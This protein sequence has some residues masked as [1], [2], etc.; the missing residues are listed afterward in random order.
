[1]K[2]NEQQQ[3]AV[4]EL[5]VSMSISAG[6]GSGKTRV[7][8]ERFRALVESGRAGID[9]IL[10]VTFTRKAAHEL[11]ERVR[12]RIDESEIAPNIKI[13]LKES[14]SRAYIGTIHSFCTRLL[15]ENPIEA[16][17]DPYFMVVEELPA[18]ELLARTAED[19]VLKQIK[20]GSPEVLAL[21]ELFGYKQLCSELQS[22]NRTLT[23]KGIKIDQI[24]ATTLKSLAEQEQLLPERISRINSALQ[25]LAALLPETDSN[26]KTYSALQEIADHCRDWQI[27]TEQVITEPAE[28]LKLL[29]HLQALGK[30]LKARTVK[31]LALELKQ[32]ADELIG[33]LTDRKTIAVLKT[34]F[35]LLRMVEKELRLRKDKRNMLEFSDLEEKAVDLLSGHPKIL[36][37]YQNHF[38]QIMVDEFQDTNYRQ[39]Q[40][41]NLL[42]G[43]ESGRN[44]FVVGDP[45]QSIYRFR[46]AEVGLFGE[47]SEQVES[48]GGIKHR[49][50]ENY[51]TREQVIKIINR[52][53]GKLMQTSEG[54][55]FQELIA[56]RTNLLSYPQV[57]L[58]LLQRDN[59]A[60]L[61]RAEAESECLARRIGELVAN[62]G[63]MVSEEEDANE[64]LRPVKYGDIAL[65]F[66]TAR[67]MDA[68]AATFSKHGIPSFIVGSRGFYQTEEIRTIL[69]VLK[70]AECCR[71]EMALA[72]MLRSPMFG[73]SDETLWLMKQAASGLGKAIGDLEQI[74]GMDKFEQAKVLMARNLIN[75]IRKLKSRF[76]LIEIIDRILGQTGFE[77]FAAML[78]NGRQMIANLDKFKNMAAAYECEHYSSL[79]GFLEYID[80]LQEK[81]VREQEAATEIE[82]GDTVKMMTVHQAKG[83]EFPV[84]IIP[85]MHRR[86]NF[87]DISAATI[88]S[89]RYGI[90]LKTQPHR[91]LLRQIAEDTERTKLEEEYKR[92]LYVAMT[93]AKDYLILSG[94]YQ[95]DNKG[96][97]KSEP[98][99]WLDWLLTENGVGEEPLVESLEESGF[100]VFNHLQS[101]IPGAA[102]TAA[103]QSG[104]AEQVIDFNLVESVAADVKEYRYRKI[105]SPTAVMDYHFCH[106]FYYFKYL[107]DVPEMKINEEYEG[108]PA[109]HYMSAAGMGTLVH[110]AIELS[111]DLDGA[112]EALNNLMAGIAAGETCPE[113]ITKLDSML[114]AF[115]ENQTVQSL[116]AT[117][118]VRKEAAYFARID[119][120]TYLQGFID[121]LY[122]ADDRAA[123]VDLKTNVID[124]ARHLEEKA[125]KYAIQLNL[126]QQAVSKI[127]GLEEVEKKLLFLRPNEMVDIP[128]MT[129]ALDLSEN[130]SSASPADCLKC[131]YY[132]LC[133]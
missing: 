88:I 46:G 74:K 102:P 55:S 28:V 120:Y 52:L 13:G 110:R 112:R 89:E 82:N 42:A 93:R 129:V 41:I 59:N 31:E 96:M 77:Y 44:L 9:E 72:G 104:E 126:Y 64:K 68:F 132:H 23:N 53:F 37:R 26:S 62:A 128:S 29:E 32:A 86:F 79:G 83:L 38:K 87:R 35:N 98:N 49:L 108:G 69:L 43:S 47:I 40:L 21:T 114:A 71:D 39:L 131:G 18:L 118:E 16:D 119:Q 75:D 5:D 95:I 54:Y 80:K 1:M 123:I 113:L 48:S 30:Q 125:R 133:R 105:I 50:D 94:Y 4:T 25:G 20:A 84:V 51:R 58:Q 116:A 76:S 8:V 3:L 33:F 115:Y 7:L 11:I 107:Q 57:E 90:F 103:G 92:L 22:I 34:L 124:N 14:L 85:E 27:G 70:S 15:K 12:K 63:I 100:K 56:G 2:L 109:E 117:C 61:E 99:S 130:D 127:L 10:T 78:P 122:L 81:D 97:V 91:G 67:D 101:D 121:Q 60:D 66:R 24:Q 111:R 65:L 73:V 36:A 19:I 45:K 106:R 6:A 17:V